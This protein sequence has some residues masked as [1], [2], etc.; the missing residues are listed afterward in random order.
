VKSTG[1]KDEALRRAALVAMKARASETELEAALAGLAADDLEAFAVRNRIGPIV[2][3]AVLRAGPSQQERERWD[4]IH[5]ASAR[6]MGILLGELD[7]VAARL[8]TAGIRLVALKNAG[9]ARGIYSCPACCPMGDVDVLVELGRFREAHRLVLECGFTH[10]S[11]SKVEPAELEHGIASGGTEYLKRVGD[12]EVWFELQW[13]PIAGRWIRKDQEPDG[14]A[15]L[16]RSVP[17]EGTDVRLLAPTDNLLQVSLH[18]AKHTYVRAPG[19]RL[20]T[21]VDRLVAF[22]PPDWTAFVAQARNLQVKT[23]VY[24]SLACARELLGTVVPAE[25]F[26]ALAP[27]PWKIRL[28]LAWLRRADFFEPDRRKFTRLGMLAFHSL[29]Y[30]DAAGLSASLMGTD[31][32]RLG[33]RHLPSN[34]ARGVRRVFDLL[35]RYQR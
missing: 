26:E 8:A 3:H 5:G 10:A 16:G 15:L 20:H 33:W 12:E 17:I 21:D 32:S 11:R 25:V 18:T 9:I 29:L 19:L 23:P 27:P 14:A 31:R 13:R 7:A 4:R 30:D 22:A 35:T 2:A 34:V 24:L 6:R 1:E 28:A